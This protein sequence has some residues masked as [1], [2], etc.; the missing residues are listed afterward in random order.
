MFIIS[1]VECLIK[2]A[3]EKVITLRVKQDLCLQK[4]AGKKLHHIVH[5]Q[6]GE[7]LSEWILSQWE[8]TRTRPLAH[9]RSLHP[10]E[11]Q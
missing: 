10:M 9:N 4:S 3:S 1:S 5:T 2:L 11:S 7:R 8:L 6:E